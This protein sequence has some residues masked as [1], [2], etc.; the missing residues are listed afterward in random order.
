MNRSR[1]VKFR[2]RST[3]FE[4]AQMFEEF[5]AIHPSYIVN[6]ELPEC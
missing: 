2:Y 4:V 6:E 5:L 1:K 3:E